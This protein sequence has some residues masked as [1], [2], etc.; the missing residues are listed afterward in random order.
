MG[1]D[2]GASHHSGH[3]QKILFHFAL[4]LAASPHVCINW[5]IYIYELPASL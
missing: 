2:T 1:P 5:T 4:N 3:H